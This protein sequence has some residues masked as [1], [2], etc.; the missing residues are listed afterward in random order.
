MLRML[1]RS[2]EKFIRQKQQVINDLKFFRSE[3]LD[4]IIRIYLKRIQI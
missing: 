2:L 3:F 1:L 4:I